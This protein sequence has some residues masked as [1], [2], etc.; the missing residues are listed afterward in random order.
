VP[1]PLLLKLLAGTAVTSI[2]CAGLVAG[3]GLPRWWPKRPPKKNR[4]AAQQ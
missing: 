1:I 3:F 4:P 2:V